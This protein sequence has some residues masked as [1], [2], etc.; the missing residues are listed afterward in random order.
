MVEIQNYM[1]NMV[2]RLRERF[3]QRLLYV[4]LQGSYL[5]GEATEGSDIDV[6][7]V[8]NELKV[9]DLDTYRQIKNAMEEPEKACGFIC[10]KEDLVHWNPMEI[11]HLLHTTKDCFGSLKPLVPEYTEEDVRNF[12]KMSVNNLYH[13]LCH[14]YIHGSREKNIAALPGT[15]RGVFF[16][17]QNLYALRTGKFVQTKAEMLDVLDGDDREVMRLCMEL[18]N[19]ETYDFDGAYSL[20]F[21][22]CQEKI[23]FLH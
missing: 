6:M 22:W 23:R 13:E 9:S 10:G 8:L 11:C 7:V 21:R 16:I 15:Y 12:V 20:L 1:E 5:R 14:R 2:R 19:A 3:G 4:G 18:K 17:L